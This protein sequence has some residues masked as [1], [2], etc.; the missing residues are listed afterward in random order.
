[1]PP[2]RWHRPDHTAAAARQQFGDLRAAL[3]PTWGD[4]PDELV[5]VGFVARSLHRNGRSI[6]HL[7]AELT[8]EVRKQLQAGLGRTEVEPGE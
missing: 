5:A 1:M 6:E 8:P 3:P 7:L 2:N 4:L